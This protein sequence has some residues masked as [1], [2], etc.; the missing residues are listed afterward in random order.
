MKQET[1]RQLAALINQMYV[2][3][4]LIACLYNGCESVLYCMEHLNNVHV[5]NLICKTLIYIVLL[6]LNWMSEILELHILI[7]NIFLVGR[8]IYS[9]IFTAALS[10]LL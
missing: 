6:E 4:Q 1:Y 7:D 2:K 8:I 10:S 5:F 9:S 3:Y